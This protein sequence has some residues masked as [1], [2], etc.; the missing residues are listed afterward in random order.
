MMAQQTPDN[1]RKIALLM[2]SLG[3]ERSAE[4]L[5]RMDGGEVSRIAREMSILDPASRQTMQSVLREF[6]EL[7]AD[8]PPAA[9]PRPVP[10]YLTT[11]SPQ[12][13]ARLLDDEPVH[14]INLLLLSLPPKTAAAVFQCLPSALKPEIARRIAEAQAPTPELRAK[15]DA[16]L[17][18]KARR[19]LD[20]QADERI[21]PSA[22]EDDAFA[23]TA[24]GPAHV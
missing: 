1:A 6:H 20:R 4:I 3:P 8:E 18:A 13:A 23:E 16:A 24:G 19:R 12:Q 21:V 17:R 2:V 7:V 22:D 15:L 9:A 5:A 14:L 10:C 11:L